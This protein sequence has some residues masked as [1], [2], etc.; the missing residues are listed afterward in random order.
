[1]NL[2]PYQQEAHDK[3]LDEFKTKGSTLYVAGTG[4]GKTVIF[5]HVIKSMQP[6][7]AMVLANRDE[8]ILQAREKISA[9]TGLSI[10]IEKADLY[11]NTGLF[12]GMPVVVSSIQTQISGPKDKR[13]YLRF[14]PH[15]FGL[16]ICDEA[17]MS[18][19]PSWREVIAHYRQNSDLKVL[20]CTA[21]PDRAD[22]QALGQIYE[23]V[24][25]EYGILDAI[26]DGWLVDITQQYVSVGSLDYSHITT[27]AGDL[28]EGQ[29]AAVMEREENMQQICQATLEA[30]HALTPQ[31]LSSVPVP[32][33][34]S[35]LS[36]LKVI[37][38]RTIIFTVSVAQA[39]MAANIFSRA[40][41]GVEW[42]CGK[43]PR[44]ARRE[45]LD[46]FQNGETHVVAN[47]GVLTTGFDNPFVELISI[48]RATKSRALY[49]QIIGR[50]TRPLPGLVDGIS[51]AEGRRA[52][53]AA[54]AKPY[55]RI[56]DFVGNSGKH[57]LITCA[58]VLGGKVSEE[59]IQDAK[60]K[61][62]EDGK[63][64]R[65]LVT[66]TNAQ[67]EIEKKQREAADRVRMEIEV[68]KNH[69]LAKSTFH[70]QN[71]NPFNNGDVMK[72]NGHNRK[73][74]DGRAFSDKQ[75]WILRR[76]GIDPSRVDYR[77]GQAIIGK[78]VAEW[79][80]KKKQR[81]AA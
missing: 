17:H 73:S 40:M 54:S 47:C 57:K 43:T 20:G 19:A 79:N 39:E 38:R 63:P 56:L 10:E 11:A 45:I 13:R 2:R 3:I 34:K 71:V 4:T 80:M 72:S 28:N 69:L 30:V 46:R 53:I 37:P 26:Q 21:T 12:N 49:T 31:T 77:Q 41:D 5:A 15:E 66:L 22:E 27:T 24:A 78:S 18:T 32:E 55:C 8:L 74:R 16:V 62:I 44:I 25:F 33:W 59:A 35:Y 52:A 70:L 6:K 9:V 60:E 67:A 61:A 23:S 7:R 58:D 65:M 48:A 14:K 50:S 64:V 75:D 76:N 81:R 1:M 29:L 68:R 36:A 42:I 51:T